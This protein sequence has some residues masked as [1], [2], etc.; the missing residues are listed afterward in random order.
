MFQ[1]QRNTVYSEGPFKFLRGTYREL[2]NQI[3]A[4]IKSGENSEYVDYDR[5]HSPK[6]TT[7]CSASTSGGYVCVFAR[8]PVCT[9]KRFGD[10][11]YRPGPARKFMWVDIN[12][13]ECVIGFDAFFRGKK[14]YSDPVADAW[15]TLEGRLAK[16]GRAIKKAEMEATAKKLGLT[17]PEYKKRLTLERLEKTNVKYAAERVGLLMKVSKLRTTV[18][19]V[20]SAI[21][22]NVISETTVQNLDS[23]DDLLGDLTW[24]LS[25]HATRNERLDEARRK[26]S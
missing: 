12:E 21:Q 13:A 5:C 26:I 17:L 9:R 10:Y 3:Q 1:I 22:K 4:E 16:E 25:R 8:V 7:L 14:D 15:M 11:Q 6:P 19:G 18:D 2:E 23:L 24:D 20:I